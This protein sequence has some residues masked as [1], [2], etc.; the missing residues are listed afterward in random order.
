MST[1]QEVMELLERAIEKLEKR[2]FTDEQLALLDQVLE[3]L[4]KK[5]KE[6]KREKVQ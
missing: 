1:K 2:E 3:S 5:I 6:V 4:M